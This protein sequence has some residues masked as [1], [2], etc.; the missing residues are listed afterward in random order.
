MVRANRAY[1][2]YLATFSWHPRGFALAGKVTAGLRAARV[3]TGIPALYKHYAGNR[4]Q[5]YPK[6]TEKARYCV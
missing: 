3:S 5:D 1:F 2:I 4:R 6:V